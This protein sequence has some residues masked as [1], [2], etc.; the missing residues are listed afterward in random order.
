MQYF[1][2]L[3]LGGVLKLASSTIMRAGFF[4][5]IPFLQNLKKENNFVVQGRGIHS[6]PSSFNRSL[7]SCDADMDES[8]IG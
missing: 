7:G 2:V 1:R 4:K 6:H 3:V 5:I 8:Y